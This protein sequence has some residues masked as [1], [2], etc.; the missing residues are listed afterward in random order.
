VVV[1]EH[2]RLLE[3]IKHLVRRHPAGARQLV[4]ICCSARDRAQR[5]GDEDAT[6]MWAEGAALIAAELEEHERWLR[7]AENAESPVHIREMRR[8][9]R[10]DD[11]QQ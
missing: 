11:D 4:G 3:R 7:L 2:E 9:M 8:V 10:E 1:T 5:L 6:V